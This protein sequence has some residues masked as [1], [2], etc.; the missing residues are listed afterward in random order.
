MVRRVPIRRLDP[1]TARRFRAG[2]RLTRRVS[3]LGVPLDPLTMDETV[4]RCGELIVSGRPVQHVVLNAGKCV[5]MEDEPDVREIIRA[6]ELVNADGQSV[7][8]AARFLGVSV[9]ERVAGIDL[10]GRLLASCE[11]EGWPVFFLGARDDVLVAFEAEARRRHPRL[12][13]VGR[14]NGYFRA[15][16]EVGIAEAI[17]R[18]GAK[19]LLVGMSSPMKERFLARNLQRMGPLL[20]MGVGGSFDVWAGRTSRAPAWMQR[21][22]LEWFHRFAQEPRRM[23]RRYLVGNLRFAWIVLRARLRPE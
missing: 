11:S 15:D 4:A 12:Q 17:R 6:C 5:L 16:E 14:R 3:F 8:W 7:V 2:T 22:G 18:S 9:P 23:W 19:L 10:M 20:A 13:V 21:V 1:T